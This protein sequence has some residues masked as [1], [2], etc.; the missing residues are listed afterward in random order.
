MLRPTIKVDY[1]GY[2]DVP[3]DGRI[4]VF[5]QFSYLNSDRSYYL[6]IVF[7]L[8][9]TDSN[10]LGEVDSLLY[11]VNDVRQVS[12]AP[13][14]R[15]VTLYVEFTD[16]PEENG[17]LTNINNVFGSVSGVSQVYQDQFESTLSDIVST[18]LAA[19]EWNPDTGKWRHS[20]FKQSLIYSPGQQ[21][22]FRVLRHPNVNTIGVD[23]A[24]NSVLRYRSQW[25]KTTAT[26]GLRVQHP[27]E[28]LDQVVWLYDGDRWIET[29]IDVNVERGIELDPSP[30]F[31]T[32]HGV[33]DI[34]KWNLYPELLDGVL[35]HLT[36]EVID[37]LASANAYKT[38]TQT[39]D[40][41]LDQRRREALRSSRY[42]ALVERMRRL[43]ESRRTVRSRFL[44]SGSRPVR[45][46]RP[47][48]VT[49]L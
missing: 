33:E 19:F 45:T 39:E 46:P 38:G 7:D 43:A 31:V 2:S 40:V 22:A 10:Y 47:L 3:M 25:T 32:D 12:L 1:V 24:W 5:Y 18:P 16:L 30:Q 11:Q 8:L 34:S 35:S 48:Y 37:Q 13:K 49:R 27:N 4:A 17:F 42:F 44:G 6:N 20:A 26:E 14:Q 41:D 15:N 28:D 36:D 23:R 21:S 9:D 29:D